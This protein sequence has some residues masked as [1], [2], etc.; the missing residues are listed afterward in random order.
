MAN[1]RELY[2]AEKKA[3]ALDQ[4]KEEVY[5]VNEEFFKLLDK[6]TITGL[7]LNV[8]NVAKITKDKMLQWTTAD[9]GEVYVD[10]LRKSIIFLIDE[11]SRYYNAVIKNTPALK[12]VHA[13]KEMFNPEREN[14]PM[15]VFKYIYDNLEYSVDLKEQIKSCKDLYEYMF[16]YID[17]ANIYIMTNEKFFEKILKIKKTLGSVSIEQLPKNEIKNDIENLPAGIENEYN[18]P[19]E[20]K[21]SEETN[22]QEQKPNE[23]EAQKMPEKPQQEQPKQNTTIQNQS[24]IP[25][26]DGDMLEEEFTMHNFLKRLNDHFRQ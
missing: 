22:K 12:D 24:Y 21:S 17:I 5:K 26:N 3:T 10:E 16:E 8:N 15:G 14:S 4:L 2:E 18:K 20:E 7:S 9:N 11:Y 1:F 23:K 6:Y 25:D 19:E 13:C